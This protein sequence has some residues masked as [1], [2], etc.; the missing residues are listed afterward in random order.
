MI[1]GFCNQCHNDR[2]RGLRFSSHKIQGTI[3]FD[4]KEQRGN[5]G[6]ALI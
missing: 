2:C 4:T 5:W 3:A 1:N 6:K